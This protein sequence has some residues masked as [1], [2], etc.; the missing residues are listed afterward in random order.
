MVTNVAFRKG[1]DKS[2]KEEYKGKNCQ[3]NLLDDLQPIADRKE[4]V[5]VIRILDGARRKLR[6]ILR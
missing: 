2:G 4:I 3:E 1:V 6:K 5:D